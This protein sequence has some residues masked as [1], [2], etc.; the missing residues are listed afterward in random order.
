MSPRATPKVQRRQR[1]P[2]LPFWN[3]VAMLVEEGKKKMKL[4]SLA[5]MTPRERLLEIATIIEDVDNRCMHHD[6]PVGD[7][8]AEMTPV[9]MRRIY[10]LAKGRERRHR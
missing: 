7:T 2:T 3:L 9:E 8:R 10:K 1:P 6:G 4:K 5:K